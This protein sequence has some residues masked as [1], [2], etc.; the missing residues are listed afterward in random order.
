MIRFPLFRLIC[1]WSFITSKRNKN[2][3]DAPLVEVRIPRGLALLAVGLIVARPAVPGEDPGLLSDM[4]NPGGMLLT[5]LS[6]GALLAWAVWRLT[7]RTGAVRAGWVEAALLTGVLALAFSA[8]FS[9]AYKR[10]AWLSVWEAAGLWALFFL[11]RQLAVDAEM[12]HGLLAAVLAGA[13]AT[14][15]AGMYQSVVQLPRFAEK[16]GDERNK[17][18]EELA[19]TN[20]T[21]GATELD[22]LFRRIQERDV[23]ATFASPEGLTAYLV[24][25]LPLLIGA[26]Y[27]NGRGIGPR[28]QTVASGA[29]A[30]LAAV[31][32]WM[33]HG[34]L[35]SWP[36]RLYVWEGT[37]KLLETKAWL[38]VGAGNFGSY[39]P[40]FMAE[41]AWEK[42]NAPHN[43]LLEAWCA[44]GLLGLAALV[45]ALC[46]FGAAVFRWWR[47]NSRGV[48]TLAPSG[49]MPNRWEIYLGGMIGLLLGFVLRL[50]SVLPEEIAGEGIAAGIRS[51]AWFAAF[52]LY[53]RIAWTERGQVLALSAGIVAGLLF[54]MTSNGIGYPA[55]AGP[56]LII[57]AL[58]LGIVAPSPN[59]WASRSILVR[60]V[61]V[62][63]IAALTLGYLVYFLLPT[64]SAST[65]AN[66]ALTSGQL[67]LQVQAH[68]TNRLAFPDPVG[69]LTQRV[70]EPLD[71]AAKDDPGNARLRIHQAIWFGQLWSK[72]TSNRAAGEQAFAHAGLAQQLNPESKDGY[73]AEYE[74][75]ARTAAILQNL[76]R[77]LD[78]Q[79]RK[80]KIDAKR[81][82]TIRGRLTG[83]LVEQR[84]LTVEALE[85]VVALDP[86]DAPVRFIYAN[87]LFAAQKRDKG[88]D[89]AREAKRLDELS[90]HPLRQLTDRQREQIARWL[91]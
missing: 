77:D 61:P 87:A 59:A 54:L 20:V 28:W 21:L 4:S 39:Y 34:G 75:R 46:T 72:E 5:L 49:E 82:W 69:F 66:R 53:E 81:Q 32:L 38:G 63:T 52:A 79:V 25:M 30:A 12:R 18:R 41:S 1:F 29:L 91:R 37:W 44:S 85:K 80:G 43:L 76:L 60:M 73:L 67:Y 50:G 70:L 19:R 45:T 64:I 31:V 36:E 90:N 40:R 7:S 83:F 16:V 57:V 62:P 33:T 65:N 74:V 24:L 11:V 88:R 58:T 78:D 22:R 84:N 71:R 9:A 48:P 51:V 14:S 35:F 68:S 3:N 10:P 6:L 55:V 27:A 26:A 2:I 56:L 47:R 13:V 17:L 42:P 23:Q 15:A 89:Q 8:A 86:T